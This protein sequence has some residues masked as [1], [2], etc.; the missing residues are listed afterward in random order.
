MFKR[1]FNPRA[2]K[3]AASAALVGVFM[4]SFVVAGVMTPVRPV[5]AQYTDPFQASLQF[6]KFGFEQALKEIV[7]VASVVTLNAASYFGN[8][9]AYSLAVSLTSDCPGQKPCWDSKGFQDGLVQAVQGSIGEAIGTLS[10]QSGLTALGFNLCKPPEP[11]FM[12]KVQ[13]G[14]LKVAES[15]PKQPKCDLNQIISNYKNFVDSV[16]SGEVLKRMSVQF[17]PGQG[18]ISAALGIQSSIGIQASDAAE[19]AVVK[20]LVCAGTGGMCDVVDKVTQR[21]VTPGLL[22]QDAAL[23]LQRESKDMP[24]L[25]T[26]IT[27]A[28]NF[29]QG[30][31][32]QVLVPAIQTFAQTLTARLLDKL[33]KSG[34]L[35]A[36]DLIA[37]QP[38]LIFS[39]EGL[40]QPAGTEGAKILQSD[41]L[42]A[43]PVESGLY[44]PLL[45]FQTCPSKN[46]NPLNCV[47]DDAFANAIRVADATPVTVGEALKKGWLKGDNVLIPATA[48]DKDD[49][50]IYCTTEAYCESNL[51]KLRAARIL[52]IGWEIAAAKSDV[53]RPVKLKDA[54]A[55]FN[56][57]DPVTGLAVAEH[58]WCHLIDP[59]WVLRMPQMRCDA[60]AFGPEL[61]SSEI[62]TRQEICVNAPSCI[63]QNDDG[64]CV[65]GYGYCMREKNIWRFGGDSCPAQYNTCRTLRP[66]LTPDRPVNYLLNTIDYGV[67]NADNAGCRAYSTT[68][69][70]TSQ[71]LTGN[72]TDLGDD[73]LI[74]PARYFNKDVETCAVGNVGCSSLVKLAQGQSLNL[75]RNGG[76]EEFEDADSDGTPEQPKVWS[77]LKPGYQAANLAQY[78]LDGSKS[79]SGRNSV[80]LSSDVSG[81]VLA[82]YGLPLKPNRTY[83]ATFSLKEEAVGGGVGSKRMD[84]F[85]YAANGNP[86]NLGQNDVS[87]SASG[88]Y[89][90]NFGSSLAFGI[91]SSNQSQA[92]A[93]CTF[94]VSK[95]FVS[96]SATVNNV[97]GPAAYIDN[98]QLEEGGG[99]SFHEGYGGDTELANI[100]VP[101]SYLGCAG[102]DSDRP[103]CSSFAGVCRENEVGC[104]SY[105]PVNGDPEV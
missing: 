65:G 105:T 97:D 79:A 69:N 30:A 80:R 76:F 93:N 44:D 58:P 37:S 54:V 74:N 3:R 15:K 70:V 9:I 63:K 31:V 72:P 82:Q 24:K 83:T 60:Q 56:D 8:Q 47:I 46:R 104:E 10:E 85:F 22:V 17:E 90:I 68:L 19:A 53:Q 1:L 99:T 33:F 39:A 49:N 38:D 103:E 88:G 5:Q 6:A 48:H 36:T 62:A 41:F 77:V 64:T 40:L 25:N 86:I 78:S 96:A 101:P 91:Q 20:K 94:S 84:I 102:E 100:K 57:C 29:A 12:L 87:F 71:G 43:R 92:T 45:V 98:I 66:R 26:V 51:K 81:D 67:C 35:N 2:W 42:S 61:V 23:R 11:N 4:F 16:S 32:S 13:L 18:A 21:V 95:P 28:G 27:M 7:G 75:V 14:I 89:C 50:P 59:D 34:L 52:P 55:K 73:W